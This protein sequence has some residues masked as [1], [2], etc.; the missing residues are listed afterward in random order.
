MFVIV[1]VYPTFGFCAYSKKKYFD[2]DLGIRPRNFACSKLDV[3]QRYI[4][5]GFD[6]CNEICNEASFAMQFHYCFLD[7]IF[8]PPKNCVQPAL[9]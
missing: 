5:L 3:L 6:V 2:P 8:L 4:F 7:Q 1:P 9:K